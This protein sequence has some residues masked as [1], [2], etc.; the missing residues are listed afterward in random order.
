MKVVQV[1]VGKGEEAMNELRMWCVRN[2]VQV[3]LVQEPYTR[4]ETGLP[5]SGGTGVRVICDESVGSR[6][7]AAIYVYDGSLEVLKVPS[8]T[9]KLSA[10][11]VVETEGERLICASVYSE[12]NDKDKKSVNIEKMKVSLELIEK[13]VEKFGEEKVLIG[14]DANAKNEWWYSGRNDVRGEMLEEAIVRMELCVLNQPG[15]PM[16]FRGYRGR[17]SN[18]DV[19]LVTQ[20]LVDECE[21]EVLTDEVG[22][23]LADHRTIVIRTKGSVSGARMESGRIRTEGVDWEEYRRELE[24]EWERRKNCDSGERELEDRVKRLTEVIVKVSEKVCGRKKR[25]N[26]RGVKWWNELLNEKKREVRRKRREYQRAQGRERM[27]KKYELEKTSKEFKR[28][29]N[30]QRFESWK[31]FVNEVGRK[32]PWSVVY[33]MQCEKMKT[34]RVLSAL[35]V[36]GS[37]TADMNETLQ[38]LCRKMFPPDQMEGESEQHERIREEMREESAGDDD[39]EVTEEEVFKGL[40]EMQNGKAPG[41]DEVEVKVMKESW[42][43]IGEELMWIV[44]RMLETGEYP[45]EWK[46]GKLVVLLKGGKPPGEVGS[47]RPITLLSVIG[48]IVEKVIVRKLR[49]WMNESGALSERQYG[50]VPGKGTTDALCKLKK[51]VKSSSKTYVAGVF[52]DVKGAFDNAWPPLVLSVMREFECPGNLYKLIRDYL[53]GRSVKVG[54]IVERFLWMIAKGCPQGSVIGPVVWL[55]LLHD[56]LRRN[57]GEG[58]SVIAYAD[59]IVIIVEADRQKDVERILNGVLRDLKEWL[60]KAKLQCSVEKTKGILLK[61]VLQQEVGCI[62]TKRE[63]RPSVRMGD[64]VIEF[65]KSL[66][67]LGVRIDESW[68][69][70]DH[71]KSAVKKASTVMHKMK[72]VNRATW[73]VGYG[74][75]NVIYEGAFLPILMYGAGLWYERVLQTHV[76]RELRA[77]Q[78]TALLAGTAA[79]RTVSWAALVALCGKLPAER[80][81]RVRGMVEERRA[82]LN[83]ERVAK[84]ERYRMVKQLESELLEKEWNEWER[85]YGEVEFDPKLGRV[86]NV[87]VKEL[88]PSVK[89]WMNEKRVVDRWILGYV[90]G[91]IG[92]GAYLFEHGK[93]PSEDCT[94]GKVETVDHVVWECEKYDSERREMMDRM[95]GVNDCKDIRE[96]KVYEAIRKSFKKMCDKLDAE[97]K[98]RR[99]EGGV[100]DPG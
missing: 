36:N 89:E 50:F 92:V 87:R 47:Y 33:R 39:L 38:V 8:V 13:I 88:V 53:S 54:R 16:T 78:R 35:S 98:A 95:R 25:G 2:R 77:G 46:V 84:D 63:W 41:V 22:V 57:F 30:K 23:A 93:E 68:L 3:A 18:V 83:E 24:W 71:V 59:D 43:V 64:E 11:C 37:E 60:D 74:V 61:G 66:V 29:I 75:M 81:V 6:V 5:V 45:S 82:E 20:D 76:K 12:G 7:K 72:R 28:M 27:R 9:T 70:K 44:R 79:Y 99:L 73:G 94:C 80:M 17:E 32:N 42:G 90:T 4:P 65:V 14:A 10:V 55:I 52:V 69:F 26:G 85:E 58:V 91:H 51:L 67:Y 56:W 62:R 86:K 31:S 97:K 40:A 100:D 1:N 21:W 34:E 96:R 15:F 19:T 49:V 48:K